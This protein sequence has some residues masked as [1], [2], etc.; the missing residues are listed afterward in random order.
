MPVRAILSAVPGVLVTCV[1]FTIGSAVPVLAQLNVV[2]EALSVAVAQHETVERTV[3]L[4]NTRNEPLAFCLSFDRPLQRSPQHMNG[5]ARLTNAAGALAGAPCGDYGE[6]L[7]R[8]DE[9]N[10]G[11]GWSPYSIEM[12]PD[13]HLLLP[14][15]G[16]PHET[17]E[18]TPSLEYVG[19]F[20]NPF[21]AMLTPF[22]A[23]LGIAYDPTG[24]GG[25]GTLWWLNTEPRSI[26][27]QNTIYRA[28]LLEGDLD[29]EP[30]GRQIELQ[31]PAMPAED[32]NVGG[33]SYDLAT[34]RFYFSG[35][36]GG[37]PEGWRAWASD[38]DGNV[39]APYPV[40]PEPYPGSF[41][42]ALSAHGGAKGGPGGT[43]GA[44]GIRF[45]YGVLAPGSVNF[46]RVVVT[47]RF[48]HDEGQALET[49]VP[50]ELF[51]AGGAGIRGNP[52]RSRLDPNGVM[53]MTFTNFDDSGVVAVRPHPLP[54]SWLVVDSEAGPEAAW[55]GMLAPG[56][57]REAVLTFQA[58][59][60]EVGTYTS[61]LQ[62]FETVSGEAIEV[63]LTLE[64][65]PGTV[66]EEEPAKPLGS[67]QLSVYPNPA[68]SDA[69]VS[70]VLPEAA[71]VQVE[72]YD[73]LG[74]RVAVLHKGRLASG[75]HR[76]RL[77]ALELPAGLY[78]IRGATGGVDATQRLSL[79]R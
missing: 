34:D 13:G 70:L 52:L 42:I 29:G 33:L 76:F 17:Y 1:L 61:S 8:L 10:L 77:A 15:T 78:L 67:T 12:T 19:A 28:L 49:P 35:F 55:D 20:Q 50:P 16:A 60:H 56:E 2:P 53:Y 25:D 43:P 45:E 6:V 36:S 66:A 21:V 39:P 4:T 54:P 74:Q 18:L 73:I 30:T 31:E 47:D 48:G 14:Q 65:T 27:G 24:A 26:N 69:V 38:R 58:G 7:A 23:T 5:S 9:G 22:A 46:D 32:F 79:V 57:S 68:S 37:D 62:A 64:V 51:E 63:P 3:V 44:E 75:E 40:L 72:V 71:D 41:M 59:A 11:F